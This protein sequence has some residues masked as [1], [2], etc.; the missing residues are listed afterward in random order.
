MYESKRKFVFGFLTGLMKGL[1][2]YNCLSHLPTQKLQN[3]GSSYL[4]SGSTGC[5][6]E[7]VWYIEAWYFLDSETQ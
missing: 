4:L 3:S 5:K 7:D 6:T 1:E 2:K